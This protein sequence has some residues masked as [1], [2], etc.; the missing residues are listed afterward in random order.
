MAEEI[1][2]DLYSPVLP[3]VGELS[4]PVPKSI[5]LSRKVECISNGYPSSMQPIPHSQKEIKER[6]SLLISR[7]FIQS[8]I[9]R[10]LNTSR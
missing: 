9:A 10:E 6:I 1:M 8:D 5:T 7:G 4:Y 3:I 2:N